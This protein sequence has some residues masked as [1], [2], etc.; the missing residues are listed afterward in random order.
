[1]CWYQDSVIGVIRITCTTEVVCK[2]K[3]KEEMNG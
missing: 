2:R 3:G 1:V